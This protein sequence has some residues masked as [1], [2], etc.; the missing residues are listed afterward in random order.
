M[1]DGL[2]VRRLLEECEL[3]ALTSDVGLDRVIRSVHHSDLAD[4]TPWMQADT[5]LIS[6]CAPLAESDSASFLYLKTI[7]EKSA[8][9]AV[10]VG[11]YVDEVSEATLRHSR[12]LGL[13][14]ISFP[15]S[16][17]IKDL[18]SYVY[19]A[20]TSSA[21]HRLRRAMAINTRL[22]DSLIERHGISE[23]LSQLA[24]MLGIGLI[25]FDRSGAVVAEASSGPR[26]DRDRIWRVYQNANGDW[27]PRGIIE[28]SHGRISVRRIFVH[29]TA[30]RI[31]GVVT[32]HPGNELTDLAMSYAE[33]LVALDIV[34][35]R[36]RVEHTQRARM[37]LLNDYLLHE[38]NA[39]DLV[40]PFRAFGIDLTDGWRIMA[41]LQF[42]P[43]HR[44][45]IS[46]ETYDTWALKLELAGDMDSRLM[47]EGRP[48]VTTVSGDLLVT[49]IQTGADSRESARARSE[50]LLS[51]MRSDRPGMTLAL[52]VSS[53]RSG[54]SNPAALVKQAIASARLAIEG[55]GVHNG[56]VLFEDVGARFRLL[57]G[58][59]I[60]S[61]TA[62]RDHIVK[63]L[64]EHDRR[65][66]TALEMTLRKY[67][68]CNMS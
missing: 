7:A 37:M 55:S 50:A 23:V 65:H 59:S 39:G 9:L 67:L 43:P 49:L 3:T 4:P 22:L 28:S 38:D 24:A 16:R 6:H 26:L 51:G 36:D 1:L 35:D 13:P 68:E 52:G 33:Q 42:P 45:P 10:A 29:G 21:V 20:L 66:H 25:L 64:A 34:H 8:A 19:E 18:H 47:A 2:T 40:E 15:K 57:D 48:S 11:T 41:L 31:L 17:A 14:L 46:R 62:M 12:A 56:V 58:Q 30:E 5:L 63:P 53:P 27:G 54:P 32:T 44:K 61:L 60:E